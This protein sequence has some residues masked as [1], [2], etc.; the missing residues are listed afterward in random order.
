MWYVYFYGLAVL[1]EEVL[2]EHTRLGTAMGDREE[3]DK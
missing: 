1:R 3:M 2:T